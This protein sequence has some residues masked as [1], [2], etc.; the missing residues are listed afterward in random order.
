ML[1]EVAA[2]LGVRVFAKPR[3]AN[4]INIDRSSSCVQRLRCGDRIRMFELR[5]ADCREY[6]EDALAGRRSGDPD[7]RLIAIGRAAEG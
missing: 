4:V 5:D 3:L 2:K 1:R 6:L 7:Q